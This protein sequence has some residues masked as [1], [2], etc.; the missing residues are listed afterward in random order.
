MKINLKKTLLYISMFLVLLY[1]FNSSISNIIYRNNF[2]CILTV[3]IGTIGMIVF[4]DKISFKKKSIL[5]LAISTIFM[6]MTLINNYYVVDGYELK[7]I[8][9]IIYLFLPLII[10]IGS[11]NVDALCKVIK[12]FFLEHIISTYIGLF[13]K[14]F[15]KSK[16]LSLICSGRSLCVASGNYYHGYIP[17]LTSHF[18]TNAIY[19]SISSLFLFSEYLT[20]KKKSTLLFFLISIVALFTAGK[21]AHLIFTIFCCIALYLYDR[22][23]KNSSG[24][25]FK[26]SLFII[27]GIIGLSILSK[28]I[29][30]ILN[31]INRFELL[32]DSGDVLNG[33]QEL[34][35]LAISL[36]NK[37]MFFGNGWGA[38]SHNYQLY[39]YNYGDVAYVDAHNVFIQLLC[40]VG[41]VG[42]LF[43]LIIM[44]TSFNKTLKLLKS[45]LNA[46]DNTL[47][48]SRFCF[49]YQLFFLLYCF[50]GNP[51]YDSQ[52]YVI[53]FMTI[54]FILF[55]SSRNREVTNE[56]SR[57]NNIL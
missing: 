2:N 44:L 56:K 41:I 33:R 34:Y 43:V 50:T 38:F 18:S 13:F 35:N 46:N 7:V 10:S 48:I 22:N 9:Y 21:R 12:I 39:L 20:N 40:E 11:N 25:I 3:T 32:I 4:Q 14:E 15:Y 8:L 19:L 49:V 55:I 5:I 51:L 16:I 26:L 45:K 29:P 37:H 42:L 28:Y 17:G 36:W 57:N 27:I 31:I 52:C 23:T 6:L 24:K 47:T 53:Y 1:P 54:G 30:E